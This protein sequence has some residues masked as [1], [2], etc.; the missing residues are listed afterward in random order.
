MMAQWKEKMEE[1]NKLSNVTGAVEPLSTNSGKFVV[2]ENVLFI[3]VL[4]SLKI[5]NKLL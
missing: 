3:V 4:S 2:N 1:F 5:K